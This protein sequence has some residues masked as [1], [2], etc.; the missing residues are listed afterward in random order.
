MGSGGG[1]TVSGLAAVRAGNVHSLR[2]TGPVI[3]LAL[4]SER[5][6]GALSTT[7]SRFDFSTYIVPKFFFFFFFFLT[8]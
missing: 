6:E 2:P 1:N 3:Q 7:F 8:S 4:A 5:S